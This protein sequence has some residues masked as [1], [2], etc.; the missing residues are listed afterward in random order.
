MKTIALLGASGKTGQHFLEQALE[1]GYNI[2][3]LVRDP[4]KII[5]ES[6]KLEIIPGDVLNPG[7]VEDLIK[8]TDLV[9]S[10]FGHVKGSPD[11][12]QTDG[13]RNI[14][15]AMKKHGVKRII[16][17]SGGGLR[18]PEKD[19]PK[20]MDKMIKGIMKL[21]VPQILKDAEKHHE[22]LSE[23]GLSWVI[24]RGPM[25][26]NDPP[27]GKYRIGWVGVNAS[28]KIA[29]ADLADLILQLVEDKSYDRQMPFVSY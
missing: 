18:F 8:N 28:T 24:V 22:V 3:A 2:K 17:L 19:Q 20:F 29:R 7:D 10:L 12:V 6:D 14:T 13:T 26:T 16:S 27:K 25:L 11:W 23:S 15:E 5:Q 21:M 9:V 4:G 1:K